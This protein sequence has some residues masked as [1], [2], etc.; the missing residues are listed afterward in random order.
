[1]GLFTQKPEER[2]AW[3]ALP[4]E[5]DER[6]DSVDRLPAP[7][8]DPLSLGLGSGASV[9]SISFEVP[10]VEDAGDAAAGAEDDHAEG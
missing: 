2:S 7:G 1:M 8:A 9:S 4:G 5:P 10:A 6:T 3:A